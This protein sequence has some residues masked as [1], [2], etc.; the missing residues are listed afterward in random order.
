MSSDEAPLRAIAL[1]GAFFIAMQKGEELTGEEIR[2]ITDR[3]VNS[4]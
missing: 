2:F 4:C 3:K 1:S